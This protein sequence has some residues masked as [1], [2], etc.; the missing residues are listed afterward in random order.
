MARGSPADPALSRRAILPRASAVAVAKSRG[1]GRHM[2]RGRR[3]GRTG[4]SGSSA[5]ADGS[6]VPENIE[7]VEYEEVP[8]GSSPEAP[9]SVGDAGVS[10][11]TGRID[12]MADPDEVREPVAAPAAEATTP[13]PA[14]AAP[15][16]LLDRP[17]RRPFGWCGG[18]RRW[19]L[20]GLRAGSD[21][22]S[23]GAPR[24]H[25]GG[26]PY[27]GERHR[28]P[29]RQARRVGRQPGRQAQ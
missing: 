25:G 8:V 7:T 26:D 24:H 14:P 15:R 16:R 23:P 2:A 22:A 18:G 28:H 10:T 12:M 6:G 9:G 29:G 13:S 1:R 5:P 17:D 21:Q 4:T 27:R 3:S 11:D 19:W 20:V